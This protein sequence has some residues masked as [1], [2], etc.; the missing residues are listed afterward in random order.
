M[1]VFEKYHYLDSGEVKKINDVSEFKEGKLYFSVTKNLRNQITFKI[2]KCVAISNELPFFD[3]LYRSVDWA[4]YKLFK[5]RHVKAK[6][7][8]FMV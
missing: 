6:L 3:E 8:E 4:N 5:E 1:I 2:S 7:E